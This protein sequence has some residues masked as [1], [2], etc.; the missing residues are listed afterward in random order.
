MHGT[1]RM[2]VVATISLIV[3]NFP[4]LAGEDCKLQGGW[5]LVSLYVKDV[6]TQ[7]RNYIYGE[8][9]SGHLRMSCDGRFDAWAGTIPNQPVL[10]IWDD[11]GRSLAEESGV[12][13][14]V[15]Y[16]GTYRVHADKLIILVD[17]ARYEGRTLHDGAYLPWKEAKSEAEQE[18]KFRNHS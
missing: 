12:L 8:H 17:K 2:I 3:S 5:R 10:S 4:V 1:A 14:A 15:Y 7:A 6:A 16:S 18:Q 11:V 13:R 9:P